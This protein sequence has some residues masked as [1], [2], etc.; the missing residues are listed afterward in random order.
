MTSGRSILKTLTST[1]SWWPRNVLL[2][3]LLTVV[4]F[5][6]ALVVLQVLVR[7]AS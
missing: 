3:I 7:V 6:L 2:R 5:Y 4:F 1:P